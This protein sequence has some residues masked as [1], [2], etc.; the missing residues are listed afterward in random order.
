VMPGTV[1]PSSAGGMPGVP[2]GEPGTFS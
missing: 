1:I 2:T